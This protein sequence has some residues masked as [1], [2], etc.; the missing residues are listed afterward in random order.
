MQ[1]KN[2]PL[3]GP[4][5][6]TSTEVCYYLLY[7]RHYQERSLESSIHSTVYTMTCGGVK[8]IIF[9]WKRGN[10]GGNLGSGAL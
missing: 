4:V 1:E 6:S 5:A 3:V 8:G 9:F 7:L 2:P 10:S